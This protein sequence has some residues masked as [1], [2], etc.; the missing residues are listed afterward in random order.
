ME[1][2]LT[3]HPEGRLSGMIVRSDSV[4]TRQRTLT[5]FA[6]K[7]YRQAHLA[8][9]TLIGLFAG[10]TVCRKSSLN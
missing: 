5:S 4:Q 8:E 10:S 7:S 2:S 1:I 9:P 6:E 3:I